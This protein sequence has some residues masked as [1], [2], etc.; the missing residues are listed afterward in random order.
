MTIDRAAL[1]FIAARFPALY[2]DSALTLRLA[3]AGATDT[4]I[5]QEAVSA[6]LRRL[7]REGYAELNVDYD[8][9]AAWGATLA[10]K[11]RWLLDGGP[12]VG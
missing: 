8:G 9:A 3:A 6:A 10:G 5:T 11:R 7:H 1:A 12:H 2:T 4:P